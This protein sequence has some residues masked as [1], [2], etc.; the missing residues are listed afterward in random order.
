MVPCADKPM[1]VRLTADDR[2]LL[3]ART[4][5][6]GMRPATMLPF[7]SAPTLPTDER[8]LK[9]SIAELEKLGA[10][11]RNIKQIARAVGGG[12]SARLDT[13]GVFRD[14]QDLRGVAR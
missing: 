12:R 9:R 5:A 7:S 14:A 3:D 1:L 10:I 11:G 4:E 6:R 13:R 2:L 8:A